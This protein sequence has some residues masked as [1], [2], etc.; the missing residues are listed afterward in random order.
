MNGRRLVHC[1]VMLCCCLSGYVAGNSPAETSLL[2][3]HHASLEIFGTD[4]SPVNANTQYSPVLLA[5]RA[6][7]PLPPQQKARFPTVRPMG[8]NLPNLLLGYLGLAP[9]GA[10]AMRKSMDSA[11]A[12][13]FTHARFIAS[14]YW[15]VDMTTGNGFVN[16]PDAYMA[17]FD[18]LVTDAE[19]R[20]L[21]LVPSLLWNIH[22]WPDI[23]KEPISALFTPGSE[24]RKRAEA[25]VSTVVKRYAGRDVILAW[26]M[27]NEFNLAADMDVSH[28]SACPD[29]GTPNVCGNLSPSHGTPCRRTAADNIFSC[30]SCRDINN[31]VTQDLGAFTASMAALVHSL[32]PGRP[33]SS[34]NAHPRPA[35]WHLS[36][37][38]C[39]HCDMTPDSPTQY[40]EALMQL[41]PPGVDWISV[42]H[43]A[44]KGRFGE[45]DTTLET[46]LQIAQNTARQAGRKLYVGEYGEKHARNASCGENTNTCNGDPALTFTRRVVTTIVNEDVPF[47]AL[48]AWDFF[49]FCPDVPTCFTVLQSDP[50]A[51]WLKLYQTAAWSCENA[52]EGAACPVGHCRSG[53]CKSVPILEASFATGTPD[54]WRHWNDCSG[55]TPSTFS[56]A[57]ADGTPAMTLATQDL[58]C[59]NVSGCQHPGA[60]VM[61]PA[62]PATPGRLMVYGDF[63]STAQSTVHV[64]ALNASGMEIAA[65]AVEIPVS[66]KWTTRGG[67]VTLPRGTSQVRLRLELG[68]PHAKIALDRLRADWRP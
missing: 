27:G 59:S 56:A 25:Y 23:S 4:A 12:A 30:N 58:P 35:A 63:L 44:E 45:T 49:Q 6:S 17:A 62:A 40:A 51:G 68:I 20:G 43:Y 16:N 50:V 21:R 42:H 3:E 36:R 54:G 14:G 8:V 15:P 64:L 13:G 9:G 47:S 24:T 39:P 26:E 5:S 48:W 11:R 65:L 7:I 2:P 38:P 41:H 33:F 66:P 18:E 61:S 28:C 19:V 53:R 60:Y 32:D 57:L 34:G 10:Q 29:D 37:H 31:T 52:A 46:L 55:C 67:V 1:L 22:L